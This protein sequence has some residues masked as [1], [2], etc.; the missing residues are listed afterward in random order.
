MGINLS[1]HNSHPNSPH[2]HPRVVELT[3]FSSKGR[4]DP[5]GICNQNPKKLV[6][7]KYSPD[8]ILTWNEVSAMAGYTPDRICDICD[9][10][11]ELLMDTGLKK[12]G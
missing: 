11:A 12:C 3:L 9:R 8:H 5:E 10:A 2:R 4:F 1:S 6:L 7:G